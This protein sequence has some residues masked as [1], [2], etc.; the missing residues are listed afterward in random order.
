MVRPMLVV[1]ALLAAGVLAARLRSLPEGTAGVLDWV[2]LRFSL[3]GLILARVPSLTLDPEVLVPA[4]VAWSVLILLL[5]LVWAV[6]RAAGW[7]R[8]TTGTL[9]L[10]VPLG[11]TSFLGI[12]AVEALLG[13]DHVIYAVLYDQLGSF[14]A[15]ATVGTVIAARF[16]G[17]DRPDAR[18]T[19]RR[20]ATFPPLV[21]LVVALAATSVEV[22]AL[23][24]DIATAF[25]ATL[26]P[27]TM[28]TVG[29][30]LTVPTDLQG[31]VPLASGLVLRLVVAPAVVVAVLASLDVSGTAAETAALE[32]AMP[33]MVTAAVVAAGAGLDS[34]LASALVGIGVIVSMGTLPLWALVIT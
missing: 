18:E 14:L 17:G 31:A 33:P 27:L 24:T 25:G 2:V 6:A 4:G 15:L 1:I 21:A 8:T 30:R 13:S 10:V 20:V 11:N 16:G 12:P 19:L 28:L 29:L 34:R 22:P 5:V 32:S 3:P 7:D 26:I 23:A 9:L